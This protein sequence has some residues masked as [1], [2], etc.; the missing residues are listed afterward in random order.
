[1]PSF[2]LASPACPLWESKPFDGLAGAEPVWCS[3]KLVSELDVLVR[4]GEESAGHVANVLSH[5]RRPLQVIIL[6]QG[7]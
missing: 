1:M 7:T 4:V 6:G 2:E 5:F 3:S